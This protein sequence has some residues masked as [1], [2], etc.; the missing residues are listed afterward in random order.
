QE[1]VCAYLRPRF[2]GLFMMGVGASFAFLS[3]EQRRAPALLQ[4]AG[5]EWLHRLAQEPRRLGRRYLIDGLPFAA[6]LFAAALSQRRR[7]AWRARRSVRTSWPTSEVDPLPFDL[8][9]GEEGVRRLVDRF[10]DLMD[11]LPEAETIRAMHAEDLALIRDKLATFLMG[12]L[13]GPRRYGE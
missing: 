4:R 1:H 8:L 2:P 10:Y 13:G 7:A 5:L 11:E 12:W 6:R 9:G 3:G